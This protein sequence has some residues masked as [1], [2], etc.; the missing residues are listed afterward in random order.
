MAQE[1]GTGYATTTIKGVMVAQLFGEDKERFILLHAKS[2]EGGGVPPG[3]S[4]AD[5]RP[6]P[7]TGGM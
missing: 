5:L 3:I 4:C 7:S 2:K 6:L 1:D